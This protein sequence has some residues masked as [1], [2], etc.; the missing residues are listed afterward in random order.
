M[1]DYLAWVSDLCDLLDAIEI[2]RLAQAW[3][4]TILG[5]TALWTPEAG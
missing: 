3:M 1:T 5:S 4:T 2:V